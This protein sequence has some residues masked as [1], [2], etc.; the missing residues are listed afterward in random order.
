[1]EISP[2]RVI[3]KKHSNKWRLIVDL[4]SPEGGSVNDGISRDLCSLSY[5]T[6]DEVAA[7]ALELGQ[8]AELGKLDIQSAYRIVPVHPDDRPL[9]GMRWKGAVFLDKALHFG[10]RSAP[11]VF[12]ALADALE[13]GGS[14]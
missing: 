6:V 3:P 1:M 7:Y 13:W 4:S 11:K 9:L 10:L 12:N 5:V 14:F 8:G 2:F